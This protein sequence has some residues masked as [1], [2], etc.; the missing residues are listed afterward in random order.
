M[1]ALDRKLAEMRSNPNSKEFVLADAKDADM[2]FG[3][4]ATGKRDY[5]SE[6]GARPASTP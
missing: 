4:R 2:A 6:V 1:K 5:L 3:V